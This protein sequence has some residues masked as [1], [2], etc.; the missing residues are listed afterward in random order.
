MVGAEEDTLMPLRRSPL[1]TVASD[2]R[3][4]TNFYLFYFI[5]LYAKDVNCKVE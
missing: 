4:M 3:V 1:E 2:G 5:S